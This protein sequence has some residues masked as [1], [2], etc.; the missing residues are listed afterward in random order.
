[1]LEPNTGQIKLPIYGPPGAQGPPGAPGHR[2]ARGE[3]GVNGIPARELP[4]PN[5]SAFFAALRNNSGPF[6]VDT[7][8]TFTHVIT[9]YGSH[10]DPDTGYYFAPYKGIYQF[11]VTISATGNQ[12]VSVFF[13]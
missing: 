13:Y 8:L 3:P 5:F 7:D 2:G 1:M 6:L 9:N 10:Y 4:L 11:I 12:E